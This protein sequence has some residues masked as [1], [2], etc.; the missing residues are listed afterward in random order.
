MLLI[1]ND[2][3]DA[4]GAIADYLSSRREAILAAWA[5]AARRDPE[6]SAPVALSRTQFFDHIPQMLD[7]LVRKLRASYLQQVLE[8]QQDEIESAEGHGIQRWQQGYNE[9]EVMR[10]WISLNACIADELEAF[11]LSRPDVDRQAMSIAWRHVSEFT[12][13]GMSE[14]VGE[15][16]RL[17]RTEAAARVQALQEAMQRLNEM[18]LERAA[19]WREAAHDLRG[20]VGVMRNVTELLRHTVR[21]EGVAAT[22]LQML[23]RSVASLHAL[24]DDLTTQARLDAGQE[25]REIRPFDV[26][27]VLRELCRTREMLA[28]EGNL[29]LECEGPDSL[30]V[31]GDEVKTRRIAQNLLQN[32]LMYTRQGGV[33]VTWEEVEQPPKRWV[34]C[35]QDTGPGL[36]PKSAAPLSA[37][38]E[39]ATRDTL[40]AQAD[41]TNVAHTSAPQPPAPTL[42]SLSPLTSKSHGEGIGLSIVKRLCELLDASIELQT[43]AGKGTTFRVTFPCR[44]VKG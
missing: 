42:P 1:M 12:V 7:A 27:A 4:V 11:A 30:P 8:A 2:L 14:S 6:L 16:S 25:A 32:A 15:Y 10:E 40:S 41:A 43:E 33:R 17:L 36:A 3:A 9:G 19:L 18:D 22:S 20:N 21:D 35:V 34:L 28:R 38:I 44:Y 26:A 29:F 39:S 24:L 5:D 13:A 31:E 23:D 37:A